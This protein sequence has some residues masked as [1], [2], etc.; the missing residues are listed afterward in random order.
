MY[1]CV[2]CC[3]L[4]ILS[5]TSPAAR[6]A[7]PPLTSTFLNEHP[8]VQ[9][10]IPAHLAHT[11]S[12]PLGV[13]LSIPLV[14]KQSLCLHRPWRWRI[15]SSQVTYTMLVSHTPSW[16]PFLQIQGCLNHSDR[17]LSFTKFT[18]EKHSIR[19]PGVGV[20]ERPLANI[21]YLVLFSVSFQF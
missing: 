6:A 1:M 17:T 2:G 8:Q 16:N 9:S 12:S 10:R 19:L 13:V 3:G 11:P 15:I 20:G 5:P 18:L 21:S 14:C 4:Q 7:C